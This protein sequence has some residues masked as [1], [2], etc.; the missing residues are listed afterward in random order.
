MLS[1]RYDGE[2]EL[3][4]SFR[5]SLYKEYAERQY[6]AVY[7]KMLTAAER[8]EYEILEKEYLEVCEALGWKPDRQPTLDTTKVDI[9]PQ[10]V[11]K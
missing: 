11:W 7:N 8:A 4:L 2:G 6:N 10:Y 9:P 1:R 5:R 3:L